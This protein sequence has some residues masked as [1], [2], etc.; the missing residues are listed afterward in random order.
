MDTIIME[1]RVTVI[2]LIR[3]LFNSFDEHPIQVNCQAGLQLGQIVSPVAV[4]LQE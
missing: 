2:I 3:E 4:R 1:L